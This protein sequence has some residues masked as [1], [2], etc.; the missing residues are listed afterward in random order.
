M[1]LVVEIPESRMSFCGAFK[2][3]VEEGDTIIL[4]ISFK[5]MY[6][7]GKRTPCLAWNFVR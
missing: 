5:S 3:R 1:F 4:Y 2:E 6:P 7:V